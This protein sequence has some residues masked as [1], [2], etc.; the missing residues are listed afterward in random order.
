MRCAVRLLV[1]ILLLVFCVNHVAAADDE[2]D[3]FI[4]GLVARYTA[5]AKTVDR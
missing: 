4:P 5:E 3:D 2:D 1:A